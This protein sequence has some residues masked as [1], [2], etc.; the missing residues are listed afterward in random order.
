[1]DGVLNSN[2]R[3]V[4]ILTSN[5]LN[6]DKNLIQRPSRIRYLKTFDDLELDV[7]KEVVMDMLQDKDFIQETVL[8]LSKLPVITIDIIKTIIQ[9]I[10]IHNQLH[11]SFKDV[12][13]V[14]EQDNLSG[15]FAKLYVLDDEGNVASVKD[16]VYLSTVPNEDSIGDDI[17]INRSWAGELHSV[18][19]D[20][21]VLDKDDKIRRYKF[22]IKDNYH[23]AFKSI[24]VSNVFV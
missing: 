2:K 13:N 22:E 11:Y 18:S 15:C 6:I 19:D 3:I 8:F 16:G 21:M 23:K 24:S 1:M 12:L 5:S 10:N 7:I 20:I 17:Y 14:N 9:E 4:F